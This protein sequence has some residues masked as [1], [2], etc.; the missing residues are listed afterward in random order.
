MTLSPI[1][2]ALLYCGKTI[3]E[4]YYFA[5]SGGNHR[6][7][8]APRE[9]FL[10]STSSAADCPASSCLKGQNVLHCLDQRLNKGIVEGSK[11]SATNPCFRGKC[12][13]CD[14]LPLVRQAHELLPPIFGVSDSPDVP[15]LFQTV[16]QQH[17]RVFIQPDVLSDLFLGYRLPATSGQQ[18]PNLP[19]AETEKQSCY[20]GYPLID[21]QSAFG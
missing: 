18:Y 3:R 10:G 9:A 7:C 1:V 12:A 16:E 20:F 14:S 17:Q 19:G 2:D 13:T 6:N 15:A 5:I 21:D 4:K 8:A 11:H